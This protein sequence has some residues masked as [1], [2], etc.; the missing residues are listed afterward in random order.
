MSTIST[1][2][3]NKTINLASI[4]LALRVGALLGSSDGLDLGGVASVEEHSLLCAAAGLLALVLLV[5]LGG[6]ALDLTG[7]CEGAVLLAH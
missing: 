5:D 6:L 1:S 4:L 3:S 2:Y 7:A